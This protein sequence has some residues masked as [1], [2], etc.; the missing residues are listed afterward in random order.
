[1]KYGRWAWLAV[2]IFYGIV[3]LLWHDWLKGSG[4]AFF[5]IQSSYGIGYGLACLLAIGV[6][7]RFRVS[8]YPAFWRILAL[9][10]SVAAAALDIKLQGYPAPLFGPL[11]ASAILGAALVSMGSRM[12]PKS[13]LIKWYGKEN[14][15][16]AD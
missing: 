16:E 9:A 6:F 10:V 1:M 3:M 5:G 7:A 13:L 12:A 15:V 4:M 11:W 14:K 8:A 2:F